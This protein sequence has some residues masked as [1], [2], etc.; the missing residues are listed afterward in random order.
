VTRPSRDGVRPPQPGWRRRF[1]RVLA[2]STALVALVPA[3]IAWAADP[4]NSLTIVGVGISAPISIRSDAQRDL[5]TALLRQVSW[6][7]GRS[8]DFAKPDLS[9]LGPKY[10]ITIFTRGVASEVYEVY[11]QASGGPRAHRP[12]TQPKGKTAEA[13]FYATVTMPNVL[14]AAGVPLP[15]PVASGQAGGAGY[16]DP[17]YQPDDIG[18]TSSFSLSKE[19]GEARMAFAATAAISVL[20]LLLLFGAAQL[21]RHRGVR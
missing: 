4:P 3:G 9:T 16:E 14:R 13:W 20:V 11:P 12:R 5:F 2:T 15:E 21:S 17:R 8:G 6:M 19:L 18:A 7:A 1:R 10:T